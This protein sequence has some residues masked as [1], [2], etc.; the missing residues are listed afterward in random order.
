MIGSLLYLTASRPDIMFSVCLCARFQDAP[1]PSHL[2]AI[3]RIFRYIK[4]TSHLGLWYPKGT[5][6]ETIVYSDSDHAGDNADR[7]S[8]SDVCTFMGSCLTSWFFKKQTAL[9]I[10]TT[11][12]EYVSAKKACQ[13]AL[14]MK[15]ALV[16]YDIDLDDILVLCDNKGA[17]DLSKNPDGPFQPKTSEGD[18]KPESQ[19]TPDERRV[20]VQDQRLKSIII[21]EGPSNTKE[22]RIID[23]KLEYQTFKAKS[24]ESLS[25]T[26]TRYKTLLN[27]L[28]NDGVNLSKHEIN[29]GFVNSH[30]EK[31]TF[32]PKSKGLVAEIFDW[33]EEEVT[34]DEKVTQVKVLMALADD[35]LTVGKSH[36]QNG[37]WV[38]ITIRKVNTILS[39]D[40][41][42][43]WQNYL[44]DELLSLK[45][46]KLNAVAFQIPNIELTKLNHALQE[47]LKEEKKIN[48]KWLTSLKQ[49]SQCIRHNRV[50]HIRGGVLAESSQSNESSIEV[51]CNTYGSTIHST[52]DHNEFDHFKREQNGVVERKNKTLIEAARTMLIGLMLSMHFW[53]EAV[54]IACYTQNRSII[55]KRHDKT[56]YEIFRERIPDI[57]YFHVF[58][59]PVFI[60]NHKDHLGKFDAKADD[61]YFLG[62]SS[63]SKA[64]RV[65][66]TRRQQIE[67]DIEDPPDLINTE[68]THEQNV[69]NDQR[70]TQLTDVP[71]GNNIKASR[72]ITKPLVPDVL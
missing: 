36:A 72:P 4:G 69:Q 57:G 51:K 15:Q 26:Y 64:F 70:I 28:A 29:V 17:I 2:E 24:T 31:W 3:K 60:H 1:K 39:M 49:V 56:P 48:E 62:Y 11:E 10:S 33:D 7:K 52:S 20:V 8:T 5:R 22:N 40:E 9:A 66:N 14:W 25:Q 21:F 35:E 27:E 46:A 42:A 68:K 55:I 30:P 23:L 53:T 18:A 45:Q 47:Q 65:Y 12:A 54:K 44:K 16:D 37:E 19:W 13:Q 58:G 59:Y 6:V 34:E 50:I 41:D 67:E 61:G 32:Q 38:D 43:D 71:S 63:V